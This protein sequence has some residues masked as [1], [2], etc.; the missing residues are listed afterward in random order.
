MFFSI[1][2]QVILGLLTQFFGIFYYWVITCATLIADLILIFVYRKK[3]KLSFNFKR[4]DWAIIFVALIS[5]FCLYQV[6]YNYTGEI[7]SV[8][9][10]ST[11]YHEVK[12]MAYPYPY[13]SDE[14]YAVSLVKGSINNHS[15]PITNIL[16]NAYFL[17]MELFFHSFVA[18]IMLILALNPVTQY[19]ILLIFFNALI[20]IL[21]YVIY[22][23]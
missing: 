8:N 2:F 9:D 17:N 20:I 10:A 23:I 22:L 12:N 15:L 19:T 13:F 7:S 1:I 6:H 5:I 16:N 11:S 18:E 21:I 3:I 14:W 4:V